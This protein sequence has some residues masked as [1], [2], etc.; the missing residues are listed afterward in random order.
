MRAST[1]LLLLPVLY[2]QAQVT[3]FF[4]GADQLPEGTDLIADVA[5]SDAEG[6]TTYLVRDGPNTEAVATIVQGPSDVALDFEFGGASV[7][8]S[9]SWEGDNVAEATCV[10]TDAEGQVGTLTAALPAITAELGTTI[11]APEPTD[12]GASGTPGSSVTSRSTAAP[13]ASSTSAPPSNP[14]SAS[15]PA[16][17]APPAASSQPADEGRLD[18]VD[19]SGDD[20]Q[21]YLDSPT[22]LEISVT[23]TGLETLALERAFLKCPFKFELVIEVWTS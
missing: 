9:C 8:G 2:A 22:P 16:S 12:G 17:S 21:A 1:F 13:G 19:S 3:I 11:G 23:G 7:A 15:K 14:S 18:C 10:L 6:R 20:I 5:G 4:P